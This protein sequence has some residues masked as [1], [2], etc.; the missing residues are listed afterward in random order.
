[1]RGELKV[2][3][4]STSADEVIVSIFTMKVYLYR[5]IQSTYLL[6]RV[7]GDPKL[8][9][10]NWIIWAVLYLS[11]HYCCEWGECMDRQSYTLGSFTIHQPRT[12]TQFWSISTYHSFECLPLHHPI[13]LRPSHTIRTASARIPGS[14]LA[15]NMPCTF[16]H[17]R[18]RRSTCWWCLLYCYLSFICVCIEADAELFPW[19]QV[20]P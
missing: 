3:C 4:C 18:N 17:I 12:K 5:L 9:C 11:T 16:S 19:L 7:E 2:E 20:F 14:K 13:I 10:Y 6:T 1:M 8:S 15:S